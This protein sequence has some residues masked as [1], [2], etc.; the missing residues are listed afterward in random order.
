MSRAGLMVLIAAVAL[1]IGAAAPQT[2]RIGGH[3]YAFP[4]AVFMGGEVE[5]GRVGTI[6]IEL[7]WPEMRPLT[8]DEAAMWP[9]RDTIRVLANSGAP[10]DGDALPEA[11]L[12]ADIPLATSLLTN[13]RSG[14]DD[15][16]SGHLRPPQPAPASE[17]PSGTVP[18]AGAQQVATEAPGPNDNRRDVFVREP[19]ERPEEVIACTRKD[20]FPDPDCEQS[21]I[22]M[23]LIVKAS[24]PRALV[25]QWRAIHDRLVAYIKGHEEKA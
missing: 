5:T 20:Q 3:T 1:C 16:Y 13:L 2:T 4:P 6:L 15:R 24:Y 8:P 7:A 17:Q 25:P 21:F 11:K 19:I 14:L 22:A 23:N 10:V 12:M 9:P 18:G